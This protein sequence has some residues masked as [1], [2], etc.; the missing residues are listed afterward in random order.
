MQGERLSVAGSGRTG[1]PATA[2][3]RCS[4][5]TPGSA[6]PPA[7]CPTCSSGPAGCAPTAASRSC[8]PTAPST[9][10][11]AVLSDWLGR[12]R[13]RCGAA[14]AVPAPRATRAPTTTSCPMP[15]RWHEWEGAAGPF[16]DIAAAR[17]SLVTTG[18]LGHVG[19]AAVPVQRRPRRA[20]RGRPDRH[21]GAGWAAPCSTSDDP[22]ARCVMVTRPQPGGIGRD[23]SVLKTIHRERGGDAR[24]RRAGAHARAP[25]APATSSRRPDGRLVG[26][27]TVELRPGEDTIRLGQLLKLVDAVPTGR[28]GEGR[29]APPGTCGSTASP[30]SGAAGSCTA[31][32]VVSVERD[33]RRP[34]RLTRLHRPFHV[35]PRTRRESGMT[36]VRPAAVTAAGARAGPPSR[37]RSSPTSRRSAP[38]STSRRSSRPTCCAEAATAAAEPPLPELD[39]TDVPL[40]TLDPPGSRDLDQAVHLA[41]AA[42]ATGSPTRSPTSAP[43]SRS[44]A[45]LDARGPPPRPDPVQP[46]PAD[47]AAP[48]GAQR[49]RREPAARAAARGRRSGRS[50]WT[51]TASRPRS[52]SAGP[53]CAAAPSWTTPSVQAQA[54]AGA[55]PESLALLPRDRRAAAGAGRRTGRHR[56]RHPRAGGRGRPPTAAGRSRCAATCRSRR[57]NAQ[58]SLL[59]GRCAA[60]LMLDGGRRH[61]AHPPAGPH[62]GRRP[63][64]GS[65]PRRSAS[66]GRPAPRPAPVIAAPRPARPGHAAFLEEAAALLR[67]AA[68]T[69]V[70]RHAARAAGP[71]RGRR[72][73]RARHR[74]AAPARRPVR[75][76]G[77]PR[78]RPPGASPAPELRAA[79]PELPALMAASDKRTRE[80]ERAVVDATEAWLL[81]GREGDGVR[82][83]RRRRRRT[84]GAP[85]CSTSPTVRGRCTGE[86]LR[87]GDPGARPARAR[88]TSPARTVRLRLDGAGTAA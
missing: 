8:C 25:C 82:R 31:G 26:V 50:T 48:A 75:H 18:T 84:G 34:D 46:R 59:T 2:A 40:V 20:R 88:P 13:R 70:R 57:W 85:S 3:G 38:S 52:I 73:V 24:R 32:D 1:S 60:G 47:P 22:I 62:R 79:L 69:P 7:G 54:D 11:D 64:C 72:P 80:V 86:G 4:T 37:R 33:G 17:V 55:L 67:G 35:E 15:P 29:A 42:T 83:R 36:D 78:A 65:S 43:S 61:P 74:A 10:D 5:R 56:A 21:A 28:P 58:I 23:T 71:R 77:L 9:A 63:A 6:S 12:P 76:G 16:H 19:P 14:G 45:P 30:R 44:A 49:G 87:A 68:Y 41:R 39:A 27:R 66:T 53:A 81:H 51:P